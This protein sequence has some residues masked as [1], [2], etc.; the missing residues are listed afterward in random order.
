MHPKFVW[1]YRDK[2]EKKLEIAVNTT[3]TIPCD[4]GSWPTMEQEGKTEWQLCP[5]C[6][7]IQSEKQ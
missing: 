1:F 3:S 5:L 4:S 7:A 2:T 6:L